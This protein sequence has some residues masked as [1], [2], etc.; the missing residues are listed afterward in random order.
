M[1]VRSHH[2][3]FDSE[4][5]KKGR[6]KQRARGREKKREGGG[7]VQVH[8]GRCVVSSGSLWASSQKA[9][10]YSVL[11]NSRDAAVSVNGR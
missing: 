8:V 4:T 10:P 7:N 11:P 2:Q 6:K 1:A 5:V 9:F 3:P